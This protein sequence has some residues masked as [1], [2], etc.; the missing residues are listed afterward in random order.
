MPRVTNALAGFHGSTCVPALRK[1]STAGMPS[2]V[3][4]ANNGTAI[5]MRCVKVNSTVNT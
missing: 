5:S 2:A 1:A 4:T 3:A